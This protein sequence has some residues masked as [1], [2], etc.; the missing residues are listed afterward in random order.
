MQD[1]GVNRLVVVSCHSKVKLASKVILILY[2]HVYFY[3]DYFIY[4]DFYY[5]DLG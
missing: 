1:F 4:S 2:K 5:A 3:S